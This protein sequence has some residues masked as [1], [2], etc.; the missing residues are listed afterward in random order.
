MKCLGR[1]YIRQFTCYTTIC[2]KNWQ[3]S[4]NGFRYLFK[5][6]ERELKKESEFLTCSASSWLY[7]PNSD[8]FSFRHYKNCTLSDV[9]TKEKLFLWEQGSFKGTFGL[10]AKVFEMLVKTAFYV[11]GRRIWAKLFFGNNFF[12]QFV[13]FRRK[14]F[15]L[16]TQILHQGCQNWNLIV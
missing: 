7:I 10:W 4:N 14:T 11:S 16:L 9:L 12:Y 2:C 6:L 8:E 1:T 13:K 15:G 3:K 5:M